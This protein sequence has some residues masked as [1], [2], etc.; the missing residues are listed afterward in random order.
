MDTSASSMFQAYI[1]VHSL[2]TLKYVPCLH[3]LPTLLAYVPCLRSLPTF[4]AYVPC[5]SSL[6]A[7]FA[8]Y[9]CSTLLLSLTEV[10]RSQ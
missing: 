4:L 8:L 2:P 9:V 10:I 7:F 1:E 3:S 6:N 5:L